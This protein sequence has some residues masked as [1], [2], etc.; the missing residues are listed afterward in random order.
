MLPPREETHNKTRP[1]PVID[2]DD[3]GKK[4]GK[5]TTDSDGLPLEGWTWE[6]RMPKFEALLKKYNATDSATWV[7]P[8]KEK[9]DIRDMTPDEIKEWEAAGKPLFMP[10]K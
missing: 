2:E 10:A 6:Q 7:K 4:S 3:V 8:E 5:K 9:A 1:M